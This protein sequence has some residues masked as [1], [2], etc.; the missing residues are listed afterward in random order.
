MARAKKK[1]KL[2]VPQKIVS[3][4]TLAMPAPVQNLL[5]NR[6]VAF[7]VVLLV[8]LMLA[9]GVATISWENGSPKFSISQEKAEKVKDMTVQKIHEVRKEKPGSSPDTG[10][11]TSLRDRIDSHR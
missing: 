11:L 8:P 9:T 2:T 6:I 1:V 4:A 10:P 5:S 3:T 7:L